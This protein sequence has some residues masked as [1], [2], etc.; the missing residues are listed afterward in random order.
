MKLNNKGVTLVEIIISIV[1]ISIVLVFLF[2]MLIQVNNETEENE[3]RASY[4]IDQASY[5][6]QIE[7]DFLDYKLKQIRKLCPSLIDGLAINKK[8]L[9][10]TYDNID[11]A[12]GDDINSYLFLYERDKPDGEKETVLSYYRDEND[13]NNF[14]Q[15]IVLEDFNWDDNSASAI[16]NNNT[17]T[18]LLNING[19][20][21]SQTYS[22]SLPLIGPDGNDYSINLSYANCS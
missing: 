4:L 13:A 6:K 19:N 2:V 10:F 8:C 20:N 17:E 12:S 14:R 18:V 15:T 11:S 22:A 16:I 1:L 21:C 9:R 7:E 5:I 3:V